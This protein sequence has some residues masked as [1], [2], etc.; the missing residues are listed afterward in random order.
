MEVKELIVKTTELK[1]GDELLGTKYHNKQLFDDDLQG[2][3]IASI[4]NQRVSY[5]R[6]NQLFWSVFGK[7][8]LFKINRNE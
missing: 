1:V 3:K 5:I 7:E 4:S 2:S 8:R 6:D